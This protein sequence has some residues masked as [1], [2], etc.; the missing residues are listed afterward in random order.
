LLAASPSEEQAADAYAKHRELAVI[1]DVID[2]D[3][4]DGADT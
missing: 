2:D 4:L 1:A 3:V